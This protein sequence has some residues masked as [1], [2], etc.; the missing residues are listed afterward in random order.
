MLEAEGRV[1]ALHIKDREKLMDV[2]IC[3]KCNV[4]ARKKG[5]KHLTDWKFKLHVKQ[6]D[7]KLKQQVKLPS[8]S[9]PYLPHIFSNKEYT[10]AVVKNL[11][12]EPLTTYITYDFETVIDPE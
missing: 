2:E 12:Y 9:L 8:I 6:C 3:P 5:D 7:G 11:P 4:F 10:E 1:H